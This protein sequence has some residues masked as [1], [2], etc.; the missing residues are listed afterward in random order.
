MPLDTRS[1]TWFIAGKWRAPGYETLVDTARIKPTRVLTS[2]GIINNARDITPLFHYIREQA[3]KLKL[4]MS[5]YDVWAKGLSNVGLSD[6]AKKI[7]LL[8]RLASLIGWAQ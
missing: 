7:Y 6:R 1:P 2:N 4:T 5:P 8:D 3:G